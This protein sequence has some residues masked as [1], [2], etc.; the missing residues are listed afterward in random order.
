LRSK[1]H[2]GYDAQFIEDCRADLTITEEDITSLLF[3]VLDE[4]ENTRGFYSLAPW[5]TDI[6]ELVHLFIDPDFIGKGAGKYLYQH[7]VETAKQLGYKKI[8]I[9]SDPFAESFYQG[10]GAV[11]IGN[12]SSSVREGRELPLM[13][14]NL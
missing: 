5:H 8:M 13:E 12:I 3:Y 7:A 2:W 9:K 10:M 6:V 4:N 14:L 11:R 1:A